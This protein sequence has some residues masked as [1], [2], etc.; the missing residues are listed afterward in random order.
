MSREKSGGVVR[1]VI[2]GGLGF[3]ALLIVLLVIAGGAFDVG[4][5]FTRQDKDHSPPL[6]LN[7][8]K[9]LSE[10][11]AAEADFE[12]II[13]RETDV[14]WLPDFVA[15][16]RVQFVAVGSVDATVDFGALDEDS[17]IFDEESNTATVI[18]PQPEMGEPRID[19]DQS[20]V[21]N[22]DRGVLDRIGGM[23][24]DSPTGE[25]ELIQEAE[26]KIAAAAEQTDLI[27]RA[28]ENTE[29]MLRNLVQGL[30]VDDV[31]VVFEAPETQPG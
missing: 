17:I 26:S 11:R 14:N 30:G 29:E 15:G 10:F 7:E 23:F 19:V 9:D 8:V 27:E 22:R 28:Q 5:P 24:V 20:G 12:V 16:D 13:D 3:V 18:L 25:I 4:L 31:R 6:I 1:S 21:M 2:F